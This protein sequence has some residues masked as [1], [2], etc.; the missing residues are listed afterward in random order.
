M[1]ASITIQAAADFLRDHDGYL[2]LTHL[3]PDGD[4]VGCAAA[5]CRA[6]RQLGKRAFVLP[7]PQAS[8]LFTPYFEGLLAE[9]GFAPDTV[10]SV[11][12]AARG[13]FPD[14]AQKYLP[15]WTGPLTTTPPRS[16]SP[17]APVWTRAGPPV[18]S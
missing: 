12:I 14:N 4:T 13:L 3:R 17:S 8:S 7:N 16:S 1:S 6:L 5:L 11:D 2:I 9:D 18:A 15:G 10:V